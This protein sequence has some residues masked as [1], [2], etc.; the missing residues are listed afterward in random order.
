[1]IRDLLD[2]TD[3]VTERERR[4]AEGEFAPS[5][6]FTDRNPLQTIKCERGIIVECFKVLEAIVKRQA[7]PAG[8]LDM[9]AGFRANSQRFHRGTQFCK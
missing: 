7:I 1:V 8:G 5:A 3:G 4:C 9:M 6:A 2:L